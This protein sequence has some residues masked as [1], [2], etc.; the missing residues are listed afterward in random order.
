MRVVER[1]MAFTP[2]KQLN[3]LKE[4][5]RIK[6]RIENMATQLDRAQPFRKEIQ[7]YAV[8]SRE[9]DDVFIV[10][11]ITPRIFAPVFNADEHFFGDRKKTRAGRG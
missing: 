6:A 7:R 8:R 3:A 11:R 9:P 10:F 2:E 1:K 4:R 5:N